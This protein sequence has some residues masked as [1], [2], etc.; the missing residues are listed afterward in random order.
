M[1]GCIG[2]EVTRWSASRMVICVGGYAALRS[3][4][5]LVRDTET[6]LLV[7]ISPSGTLNICSD[8]SSPFNRGADDGLD[9][10]SSTPLVAITAMGL[11]VKLGVEKSYSPIPLTSCVDGPGSHDISAGGLWCSYI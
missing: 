2:E 4:Y 9:G 5:D 7:I 11:I 1:L 10:C 8:P 3:V 6:H